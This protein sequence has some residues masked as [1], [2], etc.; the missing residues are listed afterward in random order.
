MSL[1]SSLLAIC[2]SVVLATPAIAQEVEIHDPYARSASP[3]AKSGAAFMVIR[4]HSGTGDRLIGVASPAAQKV[5]LHTH[6]EEDGVMRMIHVEDGFALPEGGEIRM[7]RGG[8]HVM[9]MGLTE[10][11][12][13]GKVIPMTLIF[14]T[15]GEI[16][17][18]VPVDLARKPGQGHAMGHGKH[19]DD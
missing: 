8:H 2:A 15:A 11:F 4:N 13:Q 9:L 1:K 6:R 19:A 12:E 14:E 10:P 16:T 5:E 7:Q 18:D 3:M 17:L